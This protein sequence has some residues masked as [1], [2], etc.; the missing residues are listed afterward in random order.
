VPQKPGTADKKCHKN[1][2]VRLRASLPDSGISPLPAD[3]GLP[4]QPPTKPL[5]GTTNQTRKCLLNGHLARRSRLDPGFYWDGALPGFGLRV[6]AS[7]KRSWIV[8]YRSRGYTRRVTLGDPAKVSART[9]RRTARQLLA[10]NALD[11]LP[12]APPPDAKAGITFASYAP[13]FWEQYAPHWKRLTQRAN[14]AYIDGHLIPTFGAL[15]LTDVTRANVMAWRDSMARRQGAFNRAIPVL[16]VMFKRAELLGYRRRG[17]NPCKGIPRYKRRLKERYLSA[18]ELQ[19]LGAVLRERAADRP[20]TVAAIRLLI[21]TGARRSEIEGL[22]WEWIGKD[23]ADLPDSKT[24]PK[25][26]YLNRQANAVLDGIGRKP[27]GAVFEAAGRSG[28]LWRWPEIRAA[29]GIDDVR[30]HDLRHS[31]ASLAIMQGISLTKIGGLLGHA[32]PET[33]AR[34]A[35]LADES[36]QEAASRVSGS[37]A[38]A[39]AGAQ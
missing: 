31:F 35:H 16:S 13:V 9:A 28:P 19:R 33:T 11:G 32:L 26:L 22:R 38:R 8:Q 39:L 6:F 23:L 25:R 12:V 15:P 17:S 24:G 7:T 27:V 34:Y 37:I 1:N 21:Y 14:R 18:R 10:D 4:D 2:V 3:A 20:L 36:I 30:I 29:A 5:A